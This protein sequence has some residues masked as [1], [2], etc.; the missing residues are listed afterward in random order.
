MVAAGYP[1]KRRPDGLYDG[2]Y[3]W[4]AF[5]CV[6]FLTNPATLLRTKPAS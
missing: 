2:G 1:S 6:L 3:A 4:L 5:W